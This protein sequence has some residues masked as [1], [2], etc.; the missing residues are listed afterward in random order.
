MTSDVEQIALWATSAT[1]DEV[2]E[3]LARAV[4]SGSGSFDP[5]RL[6]A[7][8]RVWFQEHEASFGAAVCPSI[9]TIVGEDSDAITVIATIAGILIG[10]AGQVPVAAFYAAALIARRALGEFCN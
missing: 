8:G 10:A 1:D 6:I 9:R 4:I 7:L 3:R 5:K 2:Y